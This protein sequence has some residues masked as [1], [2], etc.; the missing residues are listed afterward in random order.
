MLLTL[1]LDPHGFFPPGFLPIA[2][3]LLLAALGVGMTIVW[4]F[5]RGWRS[6]NRSARILTRI[7]LAGIGSWLVVGYLLNILGIL[8]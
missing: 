6:E 8:G 5:K 7:V 3:G 1:L 4:L 2:A